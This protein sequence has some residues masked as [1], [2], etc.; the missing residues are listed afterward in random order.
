MFELVRTIQQRDPARP[1]FFETLLA[2]PGLHAIG[3]HRVAHGLWRLRLRALARFLANIG[4]ILTSIEIHPGATIGRRVFIDHGIGV[5]IGETASIGDDVTIYHNVTLGG[6]DTGQPGARRHPTVNDNAVI[7]AGAQ[8]LGD[9]E[10]GE[11]ARIGANSVVIRDVAAGATVI[12]I[13][14]RTLQTKT[15]DGHAANYGISDRAAIEELARRVDELTNEI[16]TLKKG[17]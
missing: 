8:V 9:I 7:G 5:V 6:L 3:L 14:A 4:R 2:Y 17:L 11:G 16:E 1:T 10:I 13:P 15:D 12:G